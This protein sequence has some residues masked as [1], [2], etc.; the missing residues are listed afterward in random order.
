MKLEVGKFYRT[1]DGR[2]AGPVKQST[3]HPKYPY[4]ARVAGSCHTVD[5]FTENG[6]FIHSES[7]DRLD[8]VAE[9]SEPTEERI[10]REELS[11]ECV[12]EKF[13]ELVKAGQVEFRARIPGSEAHYYSWEFCLPDKREYRLKPAEPRRLVLPDSGYAC[14]RLG[15]RVDVGCQKGLNVS[16]LIEGLQCMVRSNYSTYCV[17]GLNTLN[18]TKERLLY[19]SDA[20]LTWRDA[21]ALLAFLEEGK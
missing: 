13:N 1:R 14:S 3:R 8:L 15:D 16:I 17:R 6:W 5:L 4:E 12:V 11:D 7:G 21:D 10:A 20:S 18:A 9:W 2:K 19:G